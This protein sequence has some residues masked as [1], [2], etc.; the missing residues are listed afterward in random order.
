MTEDLNTLREALELA[1]E[2]TDSRIVANKCQ[3]ALEVVHRLEAAAVPELSYGDTMRLAVKAGLLESYN[4]RRFGGYVAGG[5]E[6]MRF[7]SL[8]RSVPVGEVKPVAVVRESN[9]INPSGETVKAAFLL[10]ES[11]PAGT[12]LYTTP[13]A[14]IEGWRWVPVEPT[15]EHINSIAMRYRHDFGLMEADQRENV[16]RFARQMYE[17]CIG[18][19]FYKIAA[20]QPGDKANQ[21]HQGQEAA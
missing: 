9:P 16:R 19:G 20:P 18:E 13:P 2:E 3:K 8:V 6:L 12:P 17:E 21:A 11:L 5:A 4:E 1:F 10:D 14:P 7:A 15:E